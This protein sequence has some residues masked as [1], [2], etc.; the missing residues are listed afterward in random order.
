MFLEERINGMRE[1]IRFTRTRFA[2][3]LRCE[4]FTVGQIEIVKHL[5]HFQIHP[6]LPLIL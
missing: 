1:I 5:S 3:D 6:T 2:H 4:P